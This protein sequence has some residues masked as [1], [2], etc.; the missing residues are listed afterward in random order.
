MATRVKELE[1]LVS[2]LNLEKE[3]LLK[4]RTDTIEK[5]RFQDKE[6]KD[7]VSQRKLAMTEYNEVTDKLSELRQQKQKLSRQ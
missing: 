2:A 6:L 3:E 7:A 4:D 1:V 5:L